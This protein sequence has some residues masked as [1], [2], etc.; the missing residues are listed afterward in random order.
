MTDARVQELLDELLD[1]DATPEQVCNACPELLPVIRARWEKLQRLRQ[2]LDALFPSTDDT[3]PP[4]EDSARPELPGYEVEVEL[5]HG[6]MG[7]VFRAR[8]LRLNRLVAV[9]MMLAGAYAGPLE[10]ERFRCEA[11]AVAALRHPNIVQVHDVGEHEGRLYFTMEYVAGGSL[12]HKLAGQPQAARRAAELVATLAGAVQ[13]AHVNGIIHRDLKPS[14]I[15]LELDD[16]PKITDFG[17]ARRVAGGAE[18][19]VSGARVGTPSYMA[20]EQAQGKSSAI[21]PA[22]DIYALGAILY[23]ILTGRPPFRAET[24]T[25][26]QRQVIEEEPAAPSR[27][28]AKVPRDLETICLK[29]LHKAPARRYAS[30]ADLAADLGRFLEGKPIRARRVGALER[31]VKWAR[32]RPAAALLVAALLVGSAAAVG[33]GVWLRQKEEANRADRDRR[34]GQARQ[35]IITALA[36]ADELKHEA[37]WKEALVVL[38]HAEP[39]LS[40]ANAP[41]GRKRWSSWRTPSR[42]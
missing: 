13:C 1:S 33:V 37:R 2:N 27:L 39:L 6:G 28:N 19:T 38:A 36:R 30:A 22:V 25:E 17:L 31:G 5:G 29:C 9:K 14:N 35:G 12:A 32:R 3:P 18:L 42:S 15:L 11:L 16:T 26:T 21:G 10:R 4:P 34:E 23:E 20:P 40:E 41:E 24:A 8:H 7:I